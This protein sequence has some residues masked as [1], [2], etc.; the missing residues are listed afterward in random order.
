MRLIKSGM[1]EIFVRSKVVFTT[2]ME[3]FEKDFELLLK[4]R[5]TGNVSGRGGLKVDWRWK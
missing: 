2:F 3:C 4:G 5:T 1:R